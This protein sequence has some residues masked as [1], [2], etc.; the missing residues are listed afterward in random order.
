M[1]RKRNAP[2]ILAFPSAGG[3][4]RTPSAAERRESRLERFHRLRCVADDTNDDVTDDRLGAMRARLLR[5][6]I[7]NERVRS[8][9]PRAS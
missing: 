4:S 3:D 1:N 9:G 6:I 2:V 5:M 7:E 8:D